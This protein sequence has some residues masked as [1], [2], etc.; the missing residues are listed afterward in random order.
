MRA[1]D[2]ILLAVCGVLLV[3]GPAMALQEFVRYQASSGLAELTGQPPPLEPAFRTA[4]RGVLL[5]CVVVGGVAGTIVAIR[6]ARQARVRSVSGRLLTLLLLG[7]TLLDVAFL[8]DG[9]WFLDAPYALRGATVVW[10]Y[11]AAA[12]LMG[13]S[14]VRLTEIEGAFGERAR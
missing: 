4:W 2:W 6:C 14:V 7:L 10:L 12:I 13:G 9:R 8:A 11:P 1:S 5:L 3:A